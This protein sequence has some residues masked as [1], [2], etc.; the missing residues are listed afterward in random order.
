MGIGLVQLRENAAC[1]RDFLRDAQ[2]V[3]RLCQKQKVI[4]VINNRLDI[5]QIV[6]ADGLHLGQSDLGLKSARKIFGENKV[7]G[8]SC[9]NLSQALKAQAQGADYISVGPIFGTQT[10]PNLKPINSKLIK[11]INQRIRIPLFAIGGINR[12][13]IRKVISYGAERVAVCRAICSARDVKNSV[14]NLRNLIYN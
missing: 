11:I 14:V 9:H 6:D 13:N 4:F 8:I 1:A 3:K 7:I 10:K 12:S 5:A 2:A